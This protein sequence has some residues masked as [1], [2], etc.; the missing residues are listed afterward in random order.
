MQNINL[1]FHT[2]IFVLFITTLL[3]SCAKKDY[4]PGYK[5]GTTFPTITLK[6]YT[7]EPLGVNAG[8]KSVLIR[9]VDGIIGQE[10]VQIPFAADRDSNIVVFKKDGK[11]LPGSRINFNTPTKDTLISVFYDGR[12]FEKNP[13]FPAPA[14]GNMGLRVI[15]KTT[16]ST[17]K[18]AVDIEVHERFT[19]VIKIPVIDPLTG[20]QKKDAKGRLV[21]EDR[22]LF[23]I[24]PKVAA[25]FKNITSTE[26]SKTF[27]L[28]FGD[29]TDFQGYAFYVYKS[30]TQT[31]LSYQDNPPVSFGYFGDFIPDYTGIYEISESF[32][33]EGGKTTIGYKAEDVRIQIQ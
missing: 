24:R 14:A 6:G 12:K 30:G 4:H 11:P 1:K 31:K 25:L 3:V 27:E 19:Y 10:A 23:G 5:K 21:F 20:K 18:G 32:T 8:P 13:V 29:L 9:S 28:P 22:T 17:Y 15:F 26:F 33:I 7:V 2:Y 16:A